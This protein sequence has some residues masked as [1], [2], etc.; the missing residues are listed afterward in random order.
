MTIILVTNN[1]HQAARVAHRTAFMLEGELVELADTDTL[2]TNPADN[3]TKEY[4]EGKFG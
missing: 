3:R 1:P 2:F 4:I